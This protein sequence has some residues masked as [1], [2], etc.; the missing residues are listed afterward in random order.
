MEIVVKEDNSDVNIRKYPI[1]VKV[2]G[3]KVSAVKPITYRDVSYTLDSPVVVNAAKTSMS[4]S[5]RFSSD[6]LNLRRKF[7]EDLLN[8]YF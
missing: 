1:T 5:L 2:P 3:K 4:S 7:P 8:N 6:I